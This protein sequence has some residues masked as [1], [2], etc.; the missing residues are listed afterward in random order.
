M[1]LEPMQPASEAGTLSTELRELARHNLYHK[2]RLCAKLGLEFSH[3]R[4]DDTES[5]SFYRLLPYRDNALCSY[6]VLIGDCS[7]S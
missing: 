1:G 7:L 6:P 3:A 4:A 2:P 5:S